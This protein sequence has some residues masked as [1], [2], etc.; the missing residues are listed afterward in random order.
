MLYDWTRSRDNS[1]GTATGYGIDGWGSIPGKG[2]IFLYSSASISTLGLTQPP[3][4]WVSGF[5]SSGVKRQGR[6]ANRPYPSRAEIKI[7]RDIPSLS[8]TSSWRGVEL[9][10]HMDN[11]TFYNANCSKILQLPKGFRWT[12]VLVFELR[13]VFMNWIVH[14]ENNFS[15]GLHFPLESE[16]DSALYLLVM[17]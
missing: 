13:I 7:D 11:F 9:I 12:I 14:T 17:C 16:W 10:K 1:V 4:Q 5:F 15:L 6:A 2:K 8:L 3:T